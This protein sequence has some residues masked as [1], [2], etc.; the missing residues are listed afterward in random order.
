MKRFLKRRGSELSSVCSER[1]TEARDR[2]DNFGLVMW[3][4]ARRGLCEDGDR[5]LL[6]VHPGAKHTVSEY[7]LN[8][9]KTEGWGSEGDLF[10]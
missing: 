10:F 8:T 1:G 3:G 5:I 2:T 7:P 6:L 9:G 4:A